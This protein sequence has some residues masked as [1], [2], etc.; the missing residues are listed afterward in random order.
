MEL[1]GDMMNSEL[2]KGV[3]QQFGMK[4]NIFSCPCQN[5]LI[6]YLTICL[7]QPENVMS[8]KR[9]FDI[10]DRDGGG[11]INASE[12]G[13]LIRLSFCLDHTQCTVQPRILWHVINW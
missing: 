3:V 1:M 8:F 12:I 6:G 7:P 2:V 5:K 4:V 10:F 13:T 11:T 9:A